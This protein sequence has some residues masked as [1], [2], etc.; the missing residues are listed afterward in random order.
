M[1]EIGLQK[2]TGLGNRRTMSRIEHAI[3]ARLK[4]AHARHVFAHIAVGR[5]HDRGRPAH[6]MIA[7]EECLLLVETEAKMIGCVTRRMHGFDRPSGT[8]DELAVL[9]P[10]IGY[11]LAV[12]AFFHAWPVLMMAGAMRAKGEGLRAAPFLQ[13]LRGGRMVGMGMCDE[14]VRDRL[15]HERI[16][17]CLY[18]LRNKWTG[19]DYGNLVRADDINTRPLERDRSRIARKHAADQRRDA[20][21]GAV[22][23][24]EFTDKRYR[25]ISAPLVSACAD[26][27][28]RHEDWC[29]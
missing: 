18:V 5:C 15:A 23:R 10:H 13:R 17:Q 29:A 9:E 21:K 19:I 11:E 7:A 20:H 12:A 25:H 26:N 24:V 8:S 14:D 6:D 22:R 2:R 27:A 3:I 1:L 16:L 28:R 4:L